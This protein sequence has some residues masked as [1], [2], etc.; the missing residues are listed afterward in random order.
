MKS[1]VSFEGL[2]LGLLNY[3]DMNFNMLAKTFSGL[4]NV[5]AEELAALGAEEIQPGLRSVS[6]KGDTKLMYKANLWCRTALRILKPIH[7]FQSD[8][9]EAFY[10]GV[11]EVDWSQYITA[12]QTLAI[13]S[14]THKSNLDH[15]LYL[16]Q[17][18]KDAIA[19]QFRAKFN[20]RPS[21]D[22]NHPDLRIH[23]HISENLCTISIDSSGRSLHRRGYRDDGAIAPLNEVLAAGMILLSGWKGE[24]PFVDFM[25]GSGTLLTEAGWIAINQAPGLQQ[26]E[27]AF[28]KWKDFDRDMWF[29]LIK[30]AEKSIVPLK[31]KII[32]CDISPRTL[33]AA[34]S[35][36]KAAG[37]YGKVKVDVCDFEEL[38]A[39]EAPGIL[40]CNP[41]YGERIDV[42]DLAAL[43]KRI[44]D[45]L[46][47]QY[48][49]YEAW[50][51][52]GNKEAAKNIGLRPSVKKV[53]FNANIECKFLK[54][55]LYQG[56]KKQSRD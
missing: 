38:E 17:K 33:E 36:L 52:T 22:L 47:K 1:D 23:I 26:E 13:D 3:K 50:L 31:T 35:N 2:P 15:S 11:Q 54:F 45:V 48:S 25:C 16:S 5:L 53:L 21:V 55:E 44:G 49:G 37:L 18:G 34:K 19:D 27:F 46:K 8:N 12:E 41:P 51:L 29:E 14:V 30:E 32:G 4:E 6:F 28:E 39:P 42:N 10:K 24:K 7:S 56:S 20:V 40:M 43:Y 9:E